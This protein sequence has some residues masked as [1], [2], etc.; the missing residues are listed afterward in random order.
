M[1]K[2]IIHVYSYIR[3]HP[4]MH[5]YIYVKQ[6]M[7]NAGQN[8]GLPPLHGRNPSPC[9]PAQ[10]GGFWGPAPKRDARPHGLQPLELGGRWVRLK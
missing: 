10:L 9:C 3:T 2:E 5:I 7:Q 4:Y 6:G 8:K 1:E